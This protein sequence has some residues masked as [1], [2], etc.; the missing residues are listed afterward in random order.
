MLY[1]LDIADQAKLLES[2]T[3]LPVELI[4]YEQGR[5]R[6]EFSRRILTRKLVVEL[7][8]G[9]DPAVLQAA[10]ETG[11]IKK[12]PFAS[13]LYLV[14]TKLPGE[15]LQAADRLRKQ[16][17]VIRAEPILGRKWIRKSIP[18]DP[19]FPQQWYLL[20]KSP[21]GTS[22]GI[23]L[24]VSSVW[25]QYTGAGIT[26]TVV[27]DG[28]ELGH[29]DLSQT[30][31]TSLHYDYRDGDSNPA[32][33]GSDDYHGTAVAGILAARAH[34]DQGI[35]GI[36]FEANIGGVRLIGGDNQTDEQSS[37]ALL[38]QHQIVDIS[39]NSWGAP[40]N[41]ETLE[42]PEILSLKALETAVRDGR[43]G[44]G[45]I[46]VW[47]AGNGGEAQDNANYDG[48]ANSIYTIAVGAVTDQGA[49]SIF[50]EPGSCLVVSA[51]GEADSSSQRHG[52]ATTDLVGEIGA[53]FTGAFGDL[54]DLN[55][56]QLFGGTSAS[57]PMVSGVVALMLQA[58]PNLGWRD[59]QEILIRSARKISIADSDWITN[60]AGFHLNHKFGAGLADAAAAVNLSKSW[61]NLPTQTHLIREEKNLSDAIPDNNP[62]GVILEFEAPP[63]RV[64]HVRIRIS[65]KHSRR[66]DLAIALVSPSGTV[67]RL[68]ERHLDRNA[69]YEDWEFMSVF[70]WGENA[71]GKWL[72]QVA[73][74][75]QGT[76][77]TLNS[78]RLQIFGTAIQP[79]APTL[80]LAP[81]P[82]LTFTLTLTP[83]AA[84]RFSVESSAD[85]N[86]WTSIFDSTLAAG[87]PVN[88]V[89][90]RKSNTRFFRAVQRPD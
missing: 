5:A 15:S 76:T 70:N 17:G 2:L 3:G 58:N 7:A 45:T 12:V 39:N 81:N 60:R 1:A 56:T 64:E 65:A 43:N 27:D 21:A 37:D 80:S 32:P 62:L 79:D 54:P 68:A 13:D 88:I 24:N 38:H 29:P 33:S 52:I 53:N 55:Y 72:I 28:L 77:G 71:Q 89:A 20:N 73:D 25:D 41:G 36:A 90:S 34:N 75:R 19:L 8:P 23:D 48:F 85:L 83:H 74:L 14:E 59:V 40:D 16:P 87:E 31:N 51:P 47:S 78:A 66:G 26:V 10:P 67:S 22:S 30:A 6:D 63:L 82:D 44:K 9:L 18:N 50:S 4:L 11:A 86:S 57:A 84:G 61:R 69:D 46:F 49:H 35:A 42:G